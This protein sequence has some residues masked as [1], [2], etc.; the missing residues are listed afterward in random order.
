MNFN[1]ICCKHYFLAC[2][3]SEACAHLCGHYGHRQIEILDTLYDLR[4][5]NVGL[6]DQQPEK[7]MAS[8]LCSVEAVLAFDALRVAHI[9]HWRVHLAVETF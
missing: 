5:Q 2:S 4:N 7:V 9:R 8:L 3:V 1:N 6:V